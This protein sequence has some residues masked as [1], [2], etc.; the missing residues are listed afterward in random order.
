MP[1]LEK[2]S[3]TSPKSYTAVYREEAK[4]YTV[5]FQ[6]EDGSEIEHHEYA[7]GETPVCSATPTKAATAQY[8]YTFAW[9]PQIETI[10][11][12][13]TYKASFTQVT[14]R[15]T[16]TLKSNP[17]GA[18]TL[19]GAGTFDYGTAIAIARVDNE[20]YT[21]SNWT[22]GKTGAVVSEPPTTI[23]GDINLV[24]NFTVTNPD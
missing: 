13:A 24:A 16:V 1:A 8:S 2:V 19:T 15:Y 20:G 17:S 6:N 12:A 22:D 10:R 14:N 23:T 18:C 7:Y 11:G 4:K 3:A 9:D 5:I 21:F